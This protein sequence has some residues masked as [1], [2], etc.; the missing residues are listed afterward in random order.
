MS[1]YLYARISKKSQDITRQHRNLL[2]AYPNGKLYSEAVT[3]TTQERKQWIA[4]KKAVKPGSTI[5]FD[6]VSRMSRN[7]EAGIKDYMELFNA[8]VELVFLKEPH[9]N[10]EVYR[11]AL[12]NQVELTG[13]DVDLVL[14]GIN[15]YLIKLAERQIRIG[16]EQS[17]KEV[18]DLQQRTKEGL[19]T[20]K[21]NGVILGRRKGATIVTQKSIER[22]EKIKKLAKAFGGNLTDNEVIDVMGLGRGTYYKYKKELTAELEQLATQAEEAVTISVE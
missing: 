15:Q 6:S 17:E 14:N 10:T 22:K 18:K 8:G 4:L 13:D 5:V 16:F 19:Q 20:A 1:V 9:L 7:A 12:A 11:S 3:G 21:E 2:Q